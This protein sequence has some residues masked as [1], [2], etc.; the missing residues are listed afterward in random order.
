VDSAHDGAVARVER[1]RA[2]APG[3][4][5]ALGH[6]VDGDDAGGA[7]MARDANAHLADG[8]EPEH[9]DDPR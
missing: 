2:P 1:L 7:S 8:A 4:G 3:E 9:G 6:E 5:E